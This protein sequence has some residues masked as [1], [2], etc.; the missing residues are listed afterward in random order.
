MRTGPG[1]GLTTRSGSRQE[2]KVS[3]LEPANML[4]VQV[5]AKVNEPKQDLILLPRLVLTVYSHLQRLNFPS[6]RL[7]F[8][9]IRGGG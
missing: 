2:G 3:C 6:R 1:A 4:H 8:Y 9:Y 7:G 5:R